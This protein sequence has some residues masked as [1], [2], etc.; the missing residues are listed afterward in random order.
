MIRLARFEKL[1]IDEIARRMNRSSNAVRK[2][3]ARALPELKQGFGDTESLHLPGRHLD[4]KG[5]SDDD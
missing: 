3:L 5:L 2:L 1:R 4:L